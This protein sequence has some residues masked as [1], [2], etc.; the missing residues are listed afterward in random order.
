MPLAPSPTG[1][2]Q[3]RN[4]APDPGEVKSLA[5]LLGTLAAEAATAEILVSPKPGLVDPQDRG[6]HRDMDWTTFLIS[7]AALAPH[8]E[9]QARRGLEGISPSA[10][11]PSLQAR[12]RTMEA[13]MFAATGGINTHKGLIFALSLWLYAAGRALFLR[14]SPSLETLGTLAGAPVTGCVDRDLRSLREALPPRPLTHGERLFLE[15]GVTGIR[16][17]AEEGFPSVV[18]FGLPALREALDGGAPQEGAALGALLALMETCED[19]NVIHRGGYPYWSGPYRQEVARARR[20]FDP[21]RGNHEAL[22][23]LDRLLRAHRASPGGAADLLACTLFADRFL[24][25]LGS[26]PLFL[27][28]QRQ[29]NHEGVDLP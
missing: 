3:D 28:L 4:M 12:G 14:I 9:H 7:S 27:Y 19:S 21:L 29:Q 18:R 1:G 2:I 13:D 26:T 5:R 25:T 15:R 20:T 6:N 24:S 23:P 17:E 16:G 8:W 11:L 10:A 22:L